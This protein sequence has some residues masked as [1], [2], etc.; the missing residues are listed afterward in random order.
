VHQYGSNN[1]VEDV[2]IPIFKGLNESQ[3]EIANEWK[4]F[5]KN[6]S[7][8]KTDKNN[9]AK[10]DFENKKEDLYKNTNMELILEKIENINHRIS[11]MA[12]GLNKMNKRV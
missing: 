1:R 12:E 5:I 2:S 4:G 8:Y 11:S 3:I 10:L 7:I 9:D 6:K